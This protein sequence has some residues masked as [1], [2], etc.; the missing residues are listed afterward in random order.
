MRAIGALQACF[1]LLLRLSVCQQPQ[2]DNII[3]PEVGSGAETSQDDMRVHRSLKGRPALGC[4]VP[5]AV[6]GAELGG[7][8]GLGLL[9]VEQGMKATANAAKC[10]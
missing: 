7:V 3:I 9:C 5:E 6:V 4:P 1:L 10:Y 8:L 2:H